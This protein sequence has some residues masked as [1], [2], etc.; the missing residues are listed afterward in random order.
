MTTMN[1]AQMKASLEQFTGTEQW[2]R[3]ELYRLFTYTEGV[4][5]LSEEARCSWLVDLIFSLQYTVPK[6]KAEPFQCWKLK[7]K[8]YAATLTCED[9]NYNQIYTMDI[10]PSDFPLPE[11]DLWFIDN[12]LLLPSEY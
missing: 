2:F 3:H 11:I 12:V 6:V 8:D 10:E 1:E 7:T 9:G 5:F 4:H